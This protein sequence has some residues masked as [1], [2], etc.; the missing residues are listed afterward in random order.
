[1][2]CLPTTSL[3]PYSNST[4][5]W[6]ETSWKCSAYLPLFEFVLFCF[7]AGGFIFQAVWLGFTPPAPIYHLISVCFCCKLKQ[8]VVC[9]LKHSRQS[10]VFISHV[11]LNSENLLQWNWLEIDDLNKSQHWRYSF[12]TPLIKSWLGFVSFFCS[13]LNPD[14]GLP[15]KD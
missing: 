3:L 8:I 12:I 6:A 11:H 14:D 15:P 13:L 1:M 10:N 2:S 7:F 4:P 9:K 5:Q